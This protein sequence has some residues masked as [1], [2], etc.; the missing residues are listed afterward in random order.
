MAQTDEKIWNQLFQAA[1]SRL[2]HRVLSTFVEAGNVAAAIMTE[3]G[4][5]YTG[6][7]IDASSGLGT[8]AE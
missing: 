7:C 4:N 2:N 1:R 3:Q 5:V 6:V 8:C